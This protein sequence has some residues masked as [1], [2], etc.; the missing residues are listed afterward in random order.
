MEF[1][2]EMQGSPSPGNRP[3][4]DP[5]REL[6][7]RNQVSM[8]PTSKTPLTQHGSEGQGSASIHHSTPSS[9]V[10]LDIVTTGSDT[11]GGL[12]SPDGAD[13]F[14][15]YRPPEDL[16]SADPNRR[17]TRSADGAEAMGCIFII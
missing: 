3:K 6:G 7:S 14:P 11:G 4:G 12:A 2:G 16:T 5:N 8:G 10:D 15:E 1:G 13:R 17:R 9:A